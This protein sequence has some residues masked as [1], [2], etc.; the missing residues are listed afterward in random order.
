MIRKATKKDTEQ[1]AE[2]YKQLHRHHCEIAP[3]K[4]IMP[5][6]ELF[7]SAVFDILS[8]EGQ[9]VLVFEDEDQ[10]IRGYALVKIID[11]KD[12]MKPPRKVCFIDCFAVAEKARRQGIGTS[13]FEGVKNFAKEN[14]CN[15]VQLGVD[16]ENGS[17]RSFYKK[18]GLIPR[19]II[20]TE[21][22]N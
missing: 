4:H 5:R 21:D 6:E 12:E 13:L 15:A 2:L 17:A 16:A 19:S 9:T 3:Q 22:I 11:V 20:M 8:N 10:V 7:K 1:V 14:G 18:M